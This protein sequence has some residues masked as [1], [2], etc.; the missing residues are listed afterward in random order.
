MVVGMTADF[1]AISNDS[2]Q[3]VRIVHYIFRDDKKRCMHAMLAQDIEQFIDGF[4]ISPVVKGQEYR[5]RRC[6]L[7]KAS[8]VSKS[9]FSP[10]ESQY[11]LRHR[12]SRRT[13]ITFEEFLLEVL[14]RNIAYAVPWPHLTWKIQGI[15]RI[16]VKLCRLI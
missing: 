13:N 15:H 1:I 10:A 16:L 11:A 14:V 5:L 2:T 3:K 12:N 7:D 4:V 9:H 6:C 8:L